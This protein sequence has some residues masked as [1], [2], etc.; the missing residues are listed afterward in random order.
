MRIYRGP[1]PT[2]P[3]IIELDHDEAMTLHQVLQEYERRVS[4]PVKGELT[5]QLYKVLHG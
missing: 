5:M 2:P 3:V 4:A 1:V